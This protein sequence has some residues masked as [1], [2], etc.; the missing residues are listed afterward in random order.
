MFLKGNTIV[1]SCLYLVSKATQVFKY[2]INYFNFRVV[3]FYYKK[4]KISQIVLVD[5]NLSLLT[6]Q[7]SMKSFIKRKFSY[8]FFR[9]YLTPAAKGNKYEKK[10]Y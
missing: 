7:K 9:N 4:Q 8:I 1:S 10:A 3:K 2:N 5:N 6:I